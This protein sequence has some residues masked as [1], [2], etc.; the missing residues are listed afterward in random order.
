[1]ELNFE[2]IKRVDV[3]HGGTTANPV[4]IQII[5]EDGKH[6]TLNMR[7]ADEVEGIKVVHISE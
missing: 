1:M 4:T 6:I 2:D 3:L 5:K 7:A